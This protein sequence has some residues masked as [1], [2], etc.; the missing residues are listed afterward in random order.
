MENF[1]YLIKFDKDGVVTKVERLKKEQV[2]ETLFV[3]CDDL[4]GLVEM[5][6][7]G[8]KGM[9]NVRLIRF[10]DSQEMNGFIVESDLDLESPRFSKLIELNSLIMR[11]A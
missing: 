5:P 11:Y 4:V 10:Y 2:D 3:L 7:L 8:P 1:F 6:K 9:G